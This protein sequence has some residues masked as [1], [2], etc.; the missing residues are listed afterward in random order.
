MPL[1]NRFFCINI[2]INLVKADDFETW[3]FTIEVMGESQYKVSFPP[4]VHLAIPLSKTPITNWFLI[5]SGGS[6]HSTVSFRRAIPDIVSSRP[7]CRDGRAR[8]SHSSCTPQFQLFTLLCRSTQSLFFYLVFLIARLFQW[9]RKLGCFSVVLDNP[10]IS[11][12]CAS[13]LGNEWSPVLSVTAVCVTLQ[14][15]LASCK[16][17]RVDLFKAIC[18]Q[19]S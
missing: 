2:G 8:S 12:I 5:L 17:W 3:W 19:C 14:S 13:I 11:K 7:V 10:P 18:S 4:H 6:V 16:V 1:V 9:S 15:M